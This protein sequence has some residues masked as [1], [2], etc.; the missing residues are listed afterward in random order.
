VGEILEDSDYFMMAIVFAIVFLL[1][2]S[3]SA[4][5]MGGPLPTE[6]EALYGVIDGLDIASLYL[7]IG[8]IR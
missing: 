4:Q 6:Q 1:L 2:Q 5:R 3:Y 8:F 7:M